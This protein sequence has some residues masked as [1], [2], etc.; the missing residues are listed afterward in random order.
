MHATHAPA[1]RADMT[2]QGRKY[3]NLKVHVTELLSYGLI[4]AKNYIT[5]TVSVIIYLPNMESCEKTLGYFF[6]G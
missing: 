1:A 5:K 3:G 2:K 6:A 4:D